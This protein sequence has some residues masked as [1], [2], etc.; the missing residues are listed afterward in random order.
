MP[1]LLDEDGKMIEKFDGIIDKHVDVFLDNIKR[2]SQIG[3]FR[4]IKREK[5]AFE[6]LHPANMEYYEYAS[7]EKMLEE[8]TRQYLINDTF[9]ELF[10]TFGVTFEWPKATGKLYVGF[11]TEDIENIFKVEFIINYNGTRIGVRYSGIGNDENEIIEKY[12]LD[13]IVIIDWSDTAISKGGF[14]KTLYKDT[15]KIK[16]R[17]LK[18]FLSTYLSEELASRFIEKATSAV[19]QANDL[20]G[21]ITISKLTPQY[22]LNLKEDENNYFSG[23]VY[24]RLKYQLFNK[25]GSPCG[26]SNEIIPKEDIDIIAKAYGDNYLYNALTGIEAFAKSFL[27]SEYLWRF[28]K[29]GNNID[30]TAI[31]VGYFKSIEQLVEKIVETKLEQNDEDLWIK[32]K[33]GKPNIKNESDCKKGHNGGTAWHIRFRSC[34]KQHF[35]TTLIPLANLLSGSKKIWRISNEGKTVVCDYLLNY[36]SGCRNEHLHKDNIYSYEVTKLI[37][38]NT[39]LMIY[40]LLGACRLTGQKEINDIILGIQ[41]DS[42]DKIYKQIVR[43]PRSQCKF[44]MEFD[45]GKIIKAI[46]LFEQEKVKYDQNGSVRQSTIRFAKVEDFNVEEE[47]LLNIPKGNEIV[48]K[49]G[50]MPK[51]IWRINNGEK[52]LIE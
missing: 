52:I 30:Y 23:D 38:E 12:Q 8:Y 47:Y 14:L 2:I 21:Y 25:K 32:S 48:L 3:P 50:H 43:L 15:E 4:N 46:R 31:V 41:D 51:K 19:E 45:D 34:Y 28:F 26:Y 18:E 16:Y 17:L 40:L 11:S 20:I 7:F 33:N 49:Y 6:I 1:Y 22:L 24:Q 9:M 5:P 36:G 42:F 39:I 44:C 27:T 10:Q 29:E 35:D 13:C 37:R